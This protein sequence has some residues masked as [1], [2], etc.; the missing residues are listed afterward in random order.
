MNTN[1][2]RTPFIGGNWKMNGTRAELIQL[3]TAI[4]LGVKNLSAEIAVFPSFVY[5]SDIS[6][7]LAHSNITLGAQNQCEHEQGAYTGEISA[8]M[9]KEMGC[10]YVLLGHS[11]RRHLYRETD[12]QITQ[13]FGLA[14]KNGVRPILCVGE[15]LSERESNITN[16]VIL[17]QVNTVLA[18]V[19]IEAFSQAIVAYEPVWA[20]GTGKT[21][22]P[23]HIQEI[24]G[25]LREHFTKQNA[26]IAAELRL[27]Y[28]GSVKASNAAEI[29]AQPDVDGGLIGGA[30]LQAQEF[31][32]ICQ[33]ANR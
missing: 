16:E 6:A 2:Q 11:E 22:T 8:H 3:T 32:T 21:A 7:A 4:K 12:T 30:S 10:T 26:K 28:G 20:I 25:L 33:E 17:R 13:K 27:I 23:A 31:I 9:L 5:L 18:H 29:F 14:L 19:G 1:Y 15:T 24:H